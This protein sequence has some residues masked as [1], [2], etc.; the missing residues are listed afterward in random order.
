MEVVPFVL[1][2]E[3]VDEEM[4]WSVSSEKEKDI[5]QTRKSVG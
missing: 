3:T 2:G 1:I 4:N 5:W